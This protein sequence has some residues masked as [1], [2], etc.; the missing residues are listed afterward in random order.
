VHWYNTTRLHSAVGHIPPVEFE[1]HC[2]DAQPTPST[3]EGGL[4]PASDGSRPVHTSVAVGQAWRIRSTERCP[5]WE[6]PSSTTQNTRRA[7][8]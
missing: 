5:A 4:N 7:E 1:Q 3:P 8:A 2:R 6:E